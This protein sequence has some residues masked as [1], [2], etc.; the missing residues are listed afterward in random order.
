MATIDCLR[1]LV[2]TSHFGALDVYEMES[3]AE[4]VAPIDQYRRVFPSHVSVFDATMLAPT[5]RVAP[6]AIVTLRI[7]TSAA[8]KSPRMRSR[9]PGLLAVS[10]VASSS[11]RRPLATLQYWSNAGVEC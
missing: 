4:F 8:W 9:K 7:V 3:A 1:P 5:A 2:C 6:G 10:R 11:A